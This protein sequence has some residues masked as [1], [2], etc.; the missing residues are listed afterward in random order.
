MATQNS[1]AVTQERKGIGA[2]LAADKVQQSLSNALGD[3][4][5]I[6]R[7]VSSIVSATSV[8]P[9]LQACE[10]STVVS[11]ALLANALGLSLSPQLGYSYLVPFKEKAKYKDNVCIKPERFVATFI[12]GYKGYIQL[13][14][15]SGYYK[16]LNVV[17]IKQGELVKY[18]PLTEEIS[19][20][21]I[22]N[23]MERE[24]APT[25]G[26]YAFFEYLN[27][28]KKAIYWSKE[29]MLAH[30]DRY[31]AAFNAKDFLLVQSGKVP[32]QDMWRYSSFWYKDFDGMAFKTML[33]QLISKWGIMSIELEKAFDSDNGFVENDTVIHTESP[34][35]FDTA[36]AH[37]VANQKEVEPDIPLTAVLAKKAAKKTDKKETDYT[38]GD[39]FS[40]SDELTDEETAALDFVKDNG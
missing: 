8:N 6:Q 40:Q 30:A 23:D 39:F 38:E 19:V 9:A 31:S 20:N 32:E 5:E 10:Y 3:P 14:M 27:G 25:V 35:E 29:K 4:K 22:Q 16:R 15:R 17:A 33:R 34:V 26:Y 18:D 7:F 1:L 28:F 24:A 2:F 36:P 12:L 11:S 13:A 21:M 37:I